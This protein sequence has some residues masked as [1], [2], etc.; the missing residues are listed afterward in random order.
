[1]SIGKWLLKN[2]ENTDVDKQQALFEKSVEKNKRLETQVAKQREKLSSQQ[3]KL[4]KL[5]EKLSSLKS[6][7]LDNVSELKL[8]DSLI[9]DLREE[10]LAIVEENNALKKT[11]KE[12][13]TKIENLNL[14]KADFEDKLNN[15]INEN[16]KLQENL[17]SQDQCIKQKSVLIEQF[18][19]N[20]NVLLDKNSALANEIDQLKQSLSEKKKNYLSVLKD[21]ADAKLLITSLS[22]EK[23]TQ[24]SIVENLS[25][26]LE[27]LELQMKE[28]CISANSLE[29]DLEE[30]KKVISDL[31]K[32]K[33]DSEKLRVS[34]EK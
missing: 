25:A 27:T 22:E 32:E 9:A 1:M 7:Y 11:V 8:K 5:K 19:E 24:K 16:K 29:S 31:K 26:K 15:S 17:F 12:H 30:S 28:K 6:K 18:K 2:F 34:L 33:E 3:T 21:L 14:Q 4:N 23:E 13:L 10:N 20:E